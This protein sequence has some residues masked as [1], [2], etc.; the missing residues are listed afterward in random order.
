MVI[1]MRLALRRVG[2]AAFVAALAFPATYAA[3]AQPEHETQPV[4]IGIMRSDGILF[5]LA[6]LQRDSWTTLSVEDATTGDSQLR[7]SRGA[8]S[9]GT[10]ARTVRINAGGC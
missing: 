8:H 10:A 2:F 7:Q 3:S 6:H 4:A 9:D 1:V 5:P